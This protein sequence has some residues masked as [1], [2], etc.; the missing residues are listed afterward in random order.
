MSN[1]C[2][3]RYQYH[4]RRYN[5]VQIASYLK[6][7]LYDNLKII[8]DYK[9]YIKSSLIYGI[10]VQYRIIEFFLIQFPYNLQYAIQF[11][12]TILPYCI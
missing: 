11:E 7:T 3:R 8:L 5:H 6:Y 2:M 10:F 4:Y 1:T 9:I 12:A